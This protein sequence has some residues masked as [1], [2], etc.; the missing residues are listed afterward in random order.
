[1][2]LSL[3]SL[4][5]LIFFQLRCIN[6]FI[7]VCLCIFR[8]IIYSF[9]PGYK[10]ISEDIVLISGGGRGIGR[11]LALEFANYRPKHVMSASPV[12]HHKRFSKISLLE[13]LR[14]VVTIFLKVELI[15]QGKC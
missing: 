6:C 5:N 3:R 4:K 14:S 15:S 13:E 12:I 9:I 8:E 2:T 11:K 10:D 7:K 1:M